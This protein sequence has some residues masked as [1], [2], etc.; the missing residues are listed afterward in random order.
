MDSAEFEQ[1]LLETG[2]TR[3]SKISYYQGVLEMMAPSL[4]HEKTA[5]LFSY[6]ITT[7][8]E[9]IGIEEEEGGSTTLKN[10]NKEAA[11]EPDKCFYF[12]KHAEA[13]SGKEEIDLAVDL[14]PDLAL[15]TDNTT[16]STK[17]LKIYAALGVPEVWCYGVDKRE[18]NIYQLK[19][20]GYFL[21]KNVDT[22]KSLYLP[23]TVVNK[24]KESIEA[25]RDGA[26][27]IATKQKFRA[28]VRESNAKENLKN[29]VVSKLGV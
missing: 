11:K 1:F 3:H 14:P 5:E 25:I 17:K 20:G 9:E 12:G 18:L 28:W 26:S 23:D 24:I 27:N 4:R 13:M 7:F 6:F 8:F 2:D 21:S 29:Q 22:E 10:V 19:D 15:E 16:D